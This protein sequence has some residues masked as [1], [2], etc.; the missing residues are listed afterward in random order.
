MGRCPYLWENGIITNIGECG[1]SSYVSAINDAGQVVGWDISS[2]F[3]WKDGVTT[4]L[5]PLNSNSSFGGSQA[6]GINNKGQ[7]VGYSTTSTTVNA[8][9]WNNRSIKDLGILPGGN[10]SNVLGINRREQVVGWSNTINGMKHAVLWEN[11]AIKDL[12]LLDGNATIATSINNLG[13]V[14]GYS[15]VTN[16]YKEIPQHAFVWKNGIMRDLN[17][18]LPANSGWELNTARAINNRGQIV[19]E[20]KFSGLSAAYILTPTWT[21]N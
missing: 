12:G 8:V 16:E 1:G 2:A 13:T 18:L 4:P 7:I 19:G 14:V 20:G 10:S 5:S 3:V 6:L 17:R 21:N 11:D 15:I 9:L